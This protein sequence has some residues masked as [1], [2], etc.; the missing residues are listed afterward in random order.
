MIATT[1]VLSLSDPETVKPWIT[2]HPEVGRAGCG[3]ATTI[4]PGETEAALRGRNRAEG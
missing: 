4:L 2:A 3:G 1:G